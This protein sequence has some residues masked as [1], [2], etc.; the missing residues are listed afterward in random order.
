[1]KQKISNG[2]IIMLIIGIPLA[3]FLIY[4]DMPK[5]VRAIEPQANV[6]QV[7][8]EPQTETTELNIDYDPS[9]DWRKNEYPWAHLKL[10]LCILEDMR[11]S[12]NRKYQRIGGNTEGIGLVMKHCPK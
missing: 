6:N 2:I 1:M 3:L 9:V 10:W 7:I 8:E 11:N 12:T 4:R 5:V